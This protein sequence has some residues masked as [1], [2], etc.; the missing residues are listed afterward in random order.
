MSKTTIRFQ[1]IKI[2]GV[3]RWTE[4]GKRRQETMVFSQTVNPFNKNADGFPKTASEI[5]AELQVERDRWIA[6][7]PEFKFCEVDGP[8]MWHICKLGEG[9]ATPTLCGLMPTWEVSAKINEERLK[10]CCRTCSARYQG[11]TA[12]QKVVGEIMAGMEKI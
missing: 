3:R 7:H 8:R 4:N 10:Y 9:A 12:A 2:K 11:E 1:E 5:R 6:G